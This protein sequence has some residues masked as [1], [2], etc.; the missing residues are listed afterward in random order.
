MLRKTLIAK[1]VVLFANCHCKKHAGTVS[2]APLIL[3]SKEELV[4]MG[5]KCNGY[6]TL[7]FS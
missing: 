7:S 4:V 2:G 1:R 3:F 5:E 6:T